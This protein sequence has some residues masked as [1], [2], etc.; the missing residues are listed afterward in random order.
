MRP[1]A[2]SFWLWA[3][4]CLTAWAQPAPP[5]WPEQ[6]VPSI[7]QRVAVLDDKR[8]TESSGLCLSGRDPAVFWTHNDSGGEPC[9]FAIDQTGKTRAKVRI[10]DAVN[11]DWEDIALGQDVNGSPAL[12]IGD[13]GDNLHF[14]PSVQIY[15]VAEPAVNPPGERVDETVSEAPTLWRGHYPDGKHNAEGLLVH[16]QTGRLF[17]LTKAENG[18]CAL[19]GFPQPLQPDVSMVLEKIAT[20]VFPPV[21][22]L[23]KRP[24]DNCLT[25]AADFAQ[26]GSRLLV[27]TYSSV[28]EWT[29]PQGVPLAT[30]LQQP[31]VRIEAELVG[32]MEGACYAADGRTIWLTSERLP[33]PL[34]KV[35]RP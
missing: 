4:C 25:T 29:L 15:Q 31:P 13:I 23:G 35:T 33:A 2:L 6:P 14:R 10:K 5:P 17:I 34:V 3:G 21:T 7:S 26:D 12:F 1:A 20:L 22:R 32:Q 24:K 9:V 27:A 8:L 28:Y 19:Y 16:P 18:R 30:A 11:F